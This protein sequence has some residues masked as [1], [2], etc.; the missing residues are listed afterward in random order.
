MGM[1]FLDKFLAQV[2]GKVKVKSSSAQNVKPIAS[3]ADGRILLSNGKVMINPAVLIK[4]NAERANQTPT[5]NEA[6]QLNTLKRNLL[7]QTAYTQQARNRIAQMQFVP[8]GYTNASSYKNLSAGYTDP[9]HP[10][11]VYINR[12]TLNSSNGFPIEVLRHE[13]TH[14]LDD[15]LYGSTD[16]NGSFGNSLGFSQE[17]KNKQPNTYKYIMNTQLR[18]NAN[19]P[20][21]YNNQDQH[22]QDVEMFANL[23]GRQ[24]NRILLSPSVIAN[25]YKNMYQTVSQTYNS[26]PV[27]PS[28]EFLRMNFNPRTRNQVSFGQQSEL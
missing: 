15:N 27:Y 3:M 21:L 5:P 12:N 2:A 26:S 23:S 4:I 11:R 8:Y 14:S 6:I 19:G 13:L 1:D 18:Q 17:L 7:A 24:G 20:Q 10:N 25:R 9:S 28:N 16:I 22:T